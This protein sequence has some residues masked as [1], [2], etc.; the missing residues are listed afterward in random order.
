[1]CAVLMD[2]DFAGMY[3]F[4]ICQQYSFQRH[5]ICVTYVALFF[6]N[7][8]LIALSRGSGTISEE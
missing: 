7:C 2:D 1:M 5:E 4:E 6:F 8:L 3:I